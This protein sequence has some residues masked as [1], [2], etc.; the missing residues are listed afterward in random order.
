MLLALMGVRFFWPYNMIGHGGL[1]VDQA[2][3]RRSLPTSHQF[4]PRIRSLTLVAVLL[5]S[6][7]HVFLVS[8]QYDP[9]DP[10]GLVSERNKRA[11]ES[12]PSRKIFQPL[13]A[14]IIVFRQPAHDSACAVDHLSPQVMIGASANAAEPRSPTG[15]ILS[16]GQADPCGKLPS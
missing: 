7:G 6:R 11:I 9:G 13:G 16:W 5:R 12:S 4:T 8:G 14:P 2:S 3:K 1:I 15:C 10:C